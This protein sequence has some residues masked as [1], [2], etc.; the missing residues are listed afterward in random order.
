[1]LAPIKK[2]KHTIL[3]EHTLTDSYVDGLVFSTDEQ[4]Y[5]GIQVAYE[6]GAEDSLDLKIESSIDG[7]LTYA[8]QV[9]E[10]VATSGS[11]PVDEA[12]RNFTVSGNYWIVITPI[13][14]DAVRVSV[15]ANGD[16]PDGTVTVKAVTGWV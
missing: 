16:S 6:K 1:M 9:S 8:S 14:A 11:I 5:L 13:K 10:G 3:D 12:S 4:N 2:S 15:K 7:G